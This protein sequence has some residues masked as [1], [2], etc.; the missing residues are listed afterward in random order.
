M[1]E[2]DVSGSFLITIGRGNGPETWVV[3]SA[4]HENGKPVAF[5]FPKDL[6]EGPVH[7]F[8]AL[9]AMF[10]AD[11][12][13]LWIREVQPMEPGFCG[14]RVVAP[15]DLG[16]KLQ[17]LRPSSLGIVVTVGK[18]RG[19]ALACD[20]GGATVTSWFPDKMRKAGGK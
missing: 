6:L 15:D 5:K 9:S 12:I 16:V 14:L 3:V 10:G 18:D 7:I 8:V 20:C 19:Q 4:N 11:E 13:P 17:D 2:L 1:A